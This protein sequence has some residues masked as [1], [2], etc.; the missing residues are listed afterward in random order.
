MTA[1]QPPDEPWPVGKVARYLG[2]NTHTVHIWE[3]KGLGEAER[4]WNGHRRYWRSKV[5][6]FADELEQ[7]ERAGWPKGGRR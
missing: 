7:L 4:D 6:A 1:W 5:V 2:V 3:A